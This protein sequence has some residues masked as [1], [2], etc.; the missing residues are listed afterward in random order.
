MQFKPILAGLAVAGTLAMAIPLVHAT[1]KP[2]PINDLKVVAETNGLTTATSRAAYEERR[3]HHEERR[4][5][6]ERGRHRHGERWSLGAERSHAGSF[7]S[8]Q[9]ALNE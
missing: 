7:P 8:P 9:L 1:S 2:L 6:E 5:Y 3:R 4:R